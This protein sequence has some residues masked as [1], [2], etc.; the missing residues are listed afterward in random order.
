MISKLVIGTAQFS[1]NYGISNTSG[2][3]KP[4]MALKILR[5]AN[6]LDINF[7]DT[8]IGYKNCHKI[9][10][11]IGMK[12]FEIITKIPELQNKVER[13]LQEQERQED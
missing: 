4:D 3:V 9:L 11:K 8:A 2:K 6:K 10:G 13:L 1:S 5:L 12:N 7:I